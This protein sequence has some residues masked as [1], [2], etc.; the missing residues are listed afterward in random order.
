MP[1]VILSP[2]STSARAVLS[3][4]EGAFQPTMRILKRPTNSNSTP[5]PIAPSASAETLQEKE[6]RYQAAR[7]R[8][9]GPELSEEKPSAAV[10]EKKDKKSPKPTHAPVRNP[11]GPTTSN[12]T[13]QKGFG[14]RRTKPPTPPQSESASTA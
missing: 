6:A 10:K 2:S 8:I 1:S 13:P 7:E 4:P 12:G 9:F 11:R 3:P 14:E 5:S